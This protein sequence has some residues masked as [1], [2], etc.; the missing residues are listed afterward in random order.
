MTF[1]E[2]NIIEKYRTFQNLLN[3]STLEIASLVDLDSNIDFSPFIYEYKNKYKSSKSSQ[4]KSF[5]VNLLEEK[6]IEI[7]RIKL[8]L[9]NIEKK[10]KISKMVFLKNRS[11][12]L[13]FVDGETFFFR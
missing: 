2:E 4:I 8:Y 3:F 13:Y 5:K 1:E 11:I 12:W 9:G 6:N 7:N 10:K